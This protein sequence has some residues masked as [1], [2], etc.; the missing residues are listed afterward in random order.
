MAFCHTCELTIYQRLSHSDVFCHNVW[1]LPFLTLIHTGL[2][3]WMFLLMFASNHRHYFL[4]RSGINVY[5]YASAHQ[6]NICPIDIFR[7]ACNLEFTTCL[8]DMQPMKIFK[9]LWQKWT[10]KYQAHCAN[11]EI[12]Y[13]SNES[14]LGNLQY[15]L[16]IFSGV[17]GWG[18][19]QTQCADA[20]IAL[21][22][23]LQ[24]QLEIFSGVKVLMGRVQLKSDSFL[25]TRTHF[26]QRWK[27]NQ[28]SFAG[29]LSRKLM[30]CLQTM[31]TRFS[32][33]G[34]KLIPRNNRSKFV[35]IFRY[36]SSKP[37]CR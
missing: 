37:N 11:A 31:V 20:E 8:S 15:Q 24:D 25:A 29:I 22:M 27:L 21:A 1:M 5:F 30:Q 16:E 4:L 26:L 10:K 2:E 17:I 12:T 32:S 19:Y 13:Y 23:N 14:A 33:T 6:V 18:Q 28:V 3:W 36:D 7:Q 34:L 9:V 35:T